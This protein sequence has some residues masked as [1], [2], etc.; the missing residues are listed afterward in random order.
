MAIYYT[1][2][3]AGMLKIAAQ[4]EDK[5]GIVVA[6]IYTAFAKEASRLEEKRADMEH[7][8]LTAEIPAR[9][10]KSGEPEFIELDEEDF[11]AEELDPAE[12]ED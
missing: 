8:S 5:T 6:D 1:V 12:F 4:F 2:S 3:A 10:T 11:D 9:K 7:N